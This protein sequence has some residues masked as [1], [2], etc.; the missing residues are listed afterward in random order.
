MR[1]KEERIA[2]TYPDSVVSNGNLQF[3]LEHKT[4]FFALVFKKTLR[5]RARWNMVNI[6]LQKGALMAGEQRLQ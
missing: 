3:A 1:K 2:W 4:H 5:R 6:G